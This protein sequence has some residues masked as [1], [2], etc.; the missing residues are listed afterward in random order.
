MVSCVSFMSFT[1]AVVAAGHLRPARRP[2]RWLRDQLLRDRWRFGGR[3]L[4]AHAEFT[5]GHAF[6]DAAR[7]WHV[8]VIAAYG[9]ANVAL[10]RQQVI[11]RIETQPA[12]LWQP[13]FNPSVRGIRRRTIC[14]VAVIKIAA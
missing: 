14:V 6:E 9:S 1:V 11:S 5:I 13:G 10:A 2:P 4:H 12:Q 7:G 8:G 3:D